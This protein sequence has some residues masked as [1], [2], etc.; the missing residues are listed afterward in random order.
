M[1]LTEEPVCRYCLDS[2][3][4][5][6]SPCKCKGTQGYIHLECQKQSY[7]I[8]KS[9]ICPICVSQFTN[10]ITNYY[11]Y[12][13]EDEWIESLCTTCIQY[14]SPILHIILST[15]II[16]ITSSFALYNIIWQ[17]LISFSLILTNYMYRVKNR[18]RYLYLLFTT[19]HNNYILLHISILLYLYLTLEY[20]QSITY[21]ILLLTSTSLLHTYESQHNS[22][23]RQINAEIDITDTVL[24]IS[25]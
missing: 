14:I 9:Y 17:I 16:S 1:Q 13:E 21:Y 15:V 18:K 6:L 23:L 20:T 5:L 11:E 4:Q 22:I 3:G 2:S 12:I 8:T 24:F 10:V 7:N 19:L 25:D